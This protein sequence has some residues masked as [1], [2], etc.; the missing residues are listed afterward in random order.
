MPTNLLL[1]IFLISSFALTAHAASTPAADA[2]YQ[3]AKSAYAKLKSDEAKRKFRHHWLNVAHRFD[4]VANKWPKSDRAPEAL[5]NAA[6][7]YSELS[8][9]S[10]NAE[11]LAASE[12]A[13]RKLSEGFPK[14]KLGDD[15]A[16]GL[17]RLLADRRSDPA[18]ARAVIEAALEKGGGDSK[19]ELN[20]LLAT[21]PRPAPKPAAARPTIADAI[22]KAGRKDELKPLPIERKPVRIAAELDEEEEVVA[23]VKALAQARRAPPPR[24]EPQDEEPAL[25]PDETEAAA[26]GLKL[27]T[28][29]SL[30]ERLRD[31]RVGARPLPSQDAALSKRLKRAARDEHNAEFTLAEQLGLKMRRVV[32][33]A[34]HGGHDTGAIGPTGVLEKDVSLAISLQVAKKLSAAG[35]EVVLTRDDDT[36][37]RLE[38]RAKFA[39]QKRGDLFLSIHCNAGPN[40]TMRGIETYTLNTSANRYSIRL[41]A[42]ENATSE[43]GVSDLQFILADLATKA[44]TEESTRLAQRV[45]KSL[46]RDLSAQHKGIKDLGTKEALF[47]VLLGAKMPAILVETSF[48]SHPEEEKLLGDEKYQSQ[49]AVAISDAVTGFLEEREAKLARVD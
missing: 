29:S 23:P 47:Y 41:A 15:G 5:F 22:R 18:G 37:V 9:F 1:S 3:D 11:D 31:V 33:D 39:N 32:I 42:R 45:Q 16:F 21:L 6:E 14:H 35:L 30:Q 12:A 20:R 27:P 34:G 10:Q 2:A 46:I 43:R 44:N 4:K 48:L 7:L 25:V 40:K 8:R 26:D 28:L 13:Y 49:I 24:P 38:D 17:A 36:F 19:A